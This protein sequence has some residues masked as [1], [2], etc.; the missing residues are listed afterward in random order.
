MTSPLDPD[1]ENNFRAFLTVKNQNVRLRNGGRNFLRIVFL[2]WHR[3]DIIRG[4]VTGHK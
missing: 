4:I 1:P 3:F 2:V